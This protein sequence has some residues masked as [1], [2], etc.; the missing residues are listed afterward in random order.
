MYVHGILWDVLGMSQIH[1]TP[2]WDVYTGGVHSTPEYLNPGSV[3][4][5]WGRGHIFFR[6]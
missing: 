3:Y 4:K 1:Y 5:M 2:Q 6:K